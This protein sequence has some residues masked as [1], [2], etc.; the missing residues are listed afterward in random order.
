MQQP[1]TINALEQRI[2]DFLPSYCETTA[3]EI[4]D[5]IGVAR[6]TINKYLKILSEKKLITREIIT[7]IGGT[8]KDRRWISL[9]TKL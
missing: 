7:L 6:V 2:L 4:G 9:I 1:V 8:T 3:Q 5:G